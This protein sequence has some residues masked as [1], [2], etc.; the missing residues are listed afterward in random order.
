VPGRNQDYRLSGGEHR[1]YFLKQSPPGEG[2]VHESLAAEAALYHWAET[3][4]EAAPLRPLLPRCR[5]W[6]PERSILVLDLVTPA[7]ATAVAP[8]LLAEAL[9]VCHR[10]PVAGSVL[11]PRLS[12]TAPWIFAVARPVVAMLRELAPAQ[13]A[14]IRMLQATPAAAAGLDRLRDHWR[15]SCLIHGDIKWQNVLTLPG[16]GL[17]LVDWEM[18]QLGDPAWDVASALHALITEAVLALELREGLGS[19]EAAGLLAASTS[20]LRT[21]HQGFVRRY[22]AAAGLGPDEHR[23]LVERLPAQVAARLIK[24]A[25]EWS[26]AEP[27]LPRRAAAVLQ[28]GINM[29]CRPDQA[30]TLVLGLQAGEPVP[31]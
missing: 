22:A 25:F 19:G 4:P 20:A 30:G 5:H 29:L 16:G 27:R 3:D 15:P 10:L 12:R 8:T 7:E 1:Q 18:A 28:L 6:D 9:A 24:T 17:V 26:Q 31:P 23:A 21:D 11:A 14:V 2:G 13:L